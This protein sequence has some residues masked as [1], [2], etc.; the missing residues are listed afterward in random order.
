MRLAARTGVLL[1]ALVLSAGCAVTPLTIPQMVANRDYVEACHALHRLPKEGER[2]QARRALFRTVLPE[3]EPRV[4]V[5]VSEA[6]DG[7]D[8]K[9]GVE[10]WPLG[11]RV[12]SQD[13]VPLLGTL[14]VSFSQPRKYSLDVDLQSGKAGEHGPY[15]DRVRSFQDP[16]AH[17]WYLFDAT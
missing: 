13:G 12:P 15:F 4:R 1:S 6:G 2:A 11:E 10:F 5:A 14:Q 7:T 8:Q 17:S 16:T 3:L 9:L